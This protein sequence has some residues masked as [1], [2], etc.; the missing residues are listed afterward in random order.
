MIALYSRVSTQ[1]QN[2]H[3]YSIKE[4]QERLTAYCKSRG[5]TDYKHFTDGGFSGGNMNRPALQE[6]LRAIKHGTVARVIVYKL[7]RLSRSQKDTLELLED[8]FLPNNVDFISMCENFDTSSPFG[9]AM[10]GMFSVFAQLER[11]QIRERVTIGREARAKGGKW[12]GGSVPPVGYDYTDGQLIINDFEALQVREIFKLYLEG[13]TF[14]E[15]ATALN[16]KGWTHKYGTWQLQRVRCVLCNPVYIGMIR[17]AGQTSKGIH[18]PIID[19]KTFEK[20]SK[21]LS[22]KPIAK[23]YKRCPINVA[24]LVGKLYCGHCGARYTHTTSYSGRTQ[25]VKKL[26]YYTCVN[27]LHAKQRGK[28][29]KCDNISH[30]CDVLDAVVFDEMRKLSLEDV[31]R[32]RKELK[33]SDNVTSLQKELAKIEKQRSRLIDLYSLGSF[34]AS[35]LTSKIEPLTKSIHALEERI[36]SS[37]KR[38]VKEMQTVINSIS[39]ALDHGEPAQIRQ[40]IDALIDHIEINGEDIDIYWNFD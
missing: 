3:G 11:E 17:F 34:D 9:K 8:V 33:T 24:Y 1:E 27:R 14:T 30:R 39:D 16:A 6:M 32:Y 19:D 22:N 20:A 5:W 37:G 25:R 31:K 36:T 15:I 18:E 7:D 10:I 29:A 13:H 35:E 12:H 21:M 26:H 2:Q 40:L 38:T 23:T 4:Q 28:S